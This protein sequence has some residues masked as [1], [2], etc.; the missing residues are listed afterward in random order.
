MRKIWKKLMH[1]RLGFTLMECV[2]AAAIMGTG[3]TLV[4]SMVTV[5]YTYVSR[6]RS[7]DEIAAVAQEKVLVYSGGSGEAAT[8]GLKTY[9]G[10]ENIKYGYSDNLNVRVAYEIYYGNGTKKDVIMPSTYNFVAVIV[11]DN[12]DN[13]VVYYEVS[14]KD[15]RIKTLYTEKE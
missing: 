15:G 7:L 14:P 6:S 12:K 11:T 2:L 5:G 3:A 13:K 9:T 1:S 10:N 4:M 8:E